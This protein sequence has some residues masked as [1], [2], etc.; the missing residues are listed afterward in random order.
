M[1]GSKME[2]PHSDHAV[3]RRIAQRSRPSGRTFAIAVA[4]ALVAAC[5]SPSTGAREAGRGP[6]SALPSSIATPSIAA[7]PAQSASPS[8]PTPELSFALFGAYPVAPLGADTA[9]TLQQVLED[10][11]KSGAPDAIAA[12]ITPGG[13]WAGAAGI[14]GPDGRKATAADEFAIGSVTKLFTATLILRLAE[15]GKVDLDAPLA[16]YLGDLKANTNGATVRQT[17]AMRS[18]LG[19]YGQEEAAAI[20]ADM[21]HHWTA[22][23]REARFPVRVVGAPGAGYVSSGAGYS[24][25][26]AAAGVATDSSYALATQTEILDRVGATRILVQGAGVVT[27]EPW[28]L[29]TKAHL[30]AL[31]VQGLGAGGAISC[32]SSATFS[33]GSIASDAPS[34]AAWAW[35]LFAGDVIDTE[36]LRLMM[37]APVD[38][39]G[40]G[41]DQFTAVPGV[42]AVWETGAKT[43]YGT[44]LIVL[45]AEQIVAVL[46]VND[47]DFIA[48]PYAVQLLNIVRGS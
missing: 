32:I 23:E 7:S 12:V 24:L 47:E 29:P 8:V 20:A 33:G 14:G 2:Q 18:G 36:S 4:V 31:T 42:D 28:A 46:L 5:G 35:H 13:T 3:R 15:E 40:L 6:T 44:V 16:S 39:H 41:L 21:A 19:D 27:P 30:K 45:P 10:A 38:G 1:E 11:V 17:L 48:D 43:G 9:T 25:L 34:L 22:Q 26:A 37:P